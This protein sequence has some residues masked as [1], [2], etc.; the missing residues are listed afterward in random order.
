MGLLPLSGSANTTSSPTND[1]RVEDVNSDVPTTDDVLKRKDYVRDTYHNR[2]SLSVTRDQ[3][4]LNAL[5]GYSEGTPVIVTWFHNMESNAV[6]Q[7]N[8]SSVSFLSDSVDQSFLRINNFEF[9]VKSGF[10]FSYDNEETRS[11]LT[12]QGL[13]FPGFIP[14]QG[15]LFLYEL[16]P[17]KL[18]LFKVTNTPSRLSIR[19]GTSHEF[20]FKLHD[21]VGN[22]ELNLIYERIREEAYFDKRRFLQES[23]SLLTRDDITCLKY[24]EEKYD[25]MINFMMTNFYDDNEHDSFIRPDGV[26]D[27]YLVDFILKT[28]NTFQL[29]K[30]IIQLVQNA[31]SLDQ[32][33]FYKL[34]KPKTVSW[35]NYIPNM[36]ITSR[37][38]SAVET[39][40]NS[41]INREYLVATT[42]YEYTTP[43]DENTATQQELDD[44]DAL[45][46]AGMDV[47]GGNV[48]RYIS[49]NIGL[50][51][52]ESFSDFDTLIAFYMD[53]NVV[54][55]TILVDLCDNY[56]DWSEMDKFYRLPILMY[57]LRVVEHAI[58]TG[59][60]IRLTKA[61][62]LPYIEIP[63]KEGDDN[64]DGDLL[65]IISPD[66][67]VISLLD[68]NG[69]T[70]F[71]ESIDITY[72]DEGFVIDLENVK[73]EES[74]VTIPDSW[75]VIISNKN[76]TL[77]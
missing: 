59:Q 24:I 16:E 77:I 9:R 23:A 45:I 50:T 76:L 51:D 73:A 28:V 55:T 30:R 20:T 4:V 37:E 57:L 1:A 15:D 64:L 32:T 5:K 2:T 62:Q 70:L 3:D 69:N 72:N 63:F 26:Y 58:I 14:K 40:V 67:K 35:K 53:Q 8:I 25:E 10:D 71:I 61:N 56:Y 34:L 47:E 22:T 65:T 60:P 42:L 43:P 11:E 75:K 36:D 7:S 54:D 17:G 68:H 29:G 13:V 39:Q 46:D 74:V 49:D 41:L 48:Y 44:Y 21:I 31:P 18:G 38:L 66:A 6:K 52:Q 33:F 19:S 27:P 12:G